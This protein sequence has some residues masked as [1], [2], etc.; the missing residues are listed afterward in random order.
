M[1]SVVSLASFQ[2]LTSPGPV[3]FDFNA[4]RIVRYTLRYRTDE[5]FTGKS[6]SCIGSISF[7][8][9]CFAV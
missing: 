4:N 1:Y 3:F 2:M 7:G 6:G 5:R 9:P 8:I